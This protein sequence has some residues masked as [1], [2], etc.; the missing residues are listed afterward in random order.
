MKAY[1]IP[2]LDQFWK[3][4]FQIVTNRRPSFN[5]E[6]KDTAHIVVEP[7]HYSFRKLPHHPHI[8]SKCIDEMLL[9]K[10]ISK[11]AAIHQK[12][13]ELMAIN[14]PLTQSKQENKISLL[15][16]M[17]ERMNDNVQKICNPVFSLKM[18]FVFGSQF[19]IDILE[20]SGTAQ[21]RLK[22]YST[23]I[24]YMKDKLISS[25]EHKQNNKQSTSEIA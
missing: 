18:I 10:Y 9:I 24:T 17:M 1:C 21:P 5:P 15:I 6:V 19:F 11:L 13:R 12:D 7:L 25:K 20:R 8:I 16:Q 23:A 3:N 4:F 14:M 2:I 22:D